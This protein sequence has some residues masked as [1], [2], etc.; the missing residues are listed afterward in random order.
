MLNG[1][2]A[3]AYQTKVVFL[4]AAASDKE[5]LAAIAGGAKGIV[6]KEFAL[7][8][9]VRCIRAVASGGD[10]LPS[11]LIG[12]A[13]ERGNGHCL[14]SLRPV[15]SLT[16]REREVIPLI[17][18][19][20]LNKEV[21]RRLGVSEGTVKVHLHNIFQKTGVSCARSPMFQVLAHSITPAPSGHSC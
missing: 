14:T 9:L 13:S 18:E 11:D 3:D 2:A 15:Q 17:T 20:L 7:E 21:A 4:T 6:L 12:A 19:G 10:W 8:D 1:I 5:L 16:S